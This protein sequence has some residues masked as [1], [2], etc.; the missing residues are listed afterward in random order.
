MA[1]GRQREDSPPQW[2]PSGAQDPSP[3]PAHGA[4]GY[5]PSYRACQPGT[6]HG[7][8]P[9]SYTAR[10]NGFNGDHAVTAEQ[11]SARIVQE[12]TAEAVAVLKGEQE[13]RLPSV[14]DTANLP[15]SPPPSP[16]AEHCFG[17]LDQDVGDEEEEACPLHHFQNSRERCKFLAPSIS[18]SMPEDDPY[19]SDE[20]YYDHPLF[21][22]EWDRSVSSR[23]SVPAAAFRQIQE[24]VEALTDTFEEEEE[25]VL[26][27]EEEEMEGA[28]AEIVAALEELW[29][30]DEPELDS[31]PA[32][33]LEQAEAIGEAHTVP[34]VQAEAASAAPE[35]P[36]RRVEEKEE[37]VAEAE[38]EEESPEEALKMDMDKPDSERSGSLSPDFTEQES[39]AF[40]SGDHAAA[41]L[42]PKTDMDPPSP[43]LSSLPSNSQSQAKELSKMSILD[44]R[45]TVS[46]KQPS[47]EVLESSNLT[48]DSGSGF[49]RAEDRGQGQGVPSDSNKDKSGMSAYFETSAL[50]PDEGSKGV[51][52]EGYYELSTAGEEK[53][54]LGSSSPTVPSPLEINYSMLAQTQSVEEKSDTKKSLMGDQKETLPALDR[55]NECRLSPGK[56]ALDQRSY[57]LNITIGSIDPSGHGL[58]RNFS[59]LATDIMSFTSGSLEES[60]NYLPVTTP[61]VE[62]EPTPFPPLI[63]ETAASV[64]SD[65]SSPPHDTATETP[66][67]KTSPQGSESPESPFPPKY[68]YKNGTVMAPDLPEMLDLAGSR[69][70]LASENTDPEIM[71]RKSVPADAQGLGSDSLAN[72]VLGDQSQ[73][74]SLAKS[75]S[76]LEELGYCVFSEYSGPMPSPADLHSPIDSPPQRFT[77]MALEEK[78]AEEKL[79]IDARDKLAED[80]KT[81]QLAESAGSNEKEETKQMGQKDSASEEKDNKK[82]SHEN[83]SMENQKDKPASAL[84]SAESFV[85]PTVTV[86]L[87]EEEKLGDNGP[88]T[89][90]EIAAYERQ[91]RRLEMEDRPLSMEEEREL[92]ELREKVKDK[93]L[94]H[95]EAYEEVDA[96]DVYQLTGVAKDRI[97]RPVRPS[98]ASSVESTTEEDNVSV[99]ETEKPKQTG[100]QTTPTK[101]DVMAMSPS[102]S[103]DCVSTT[104][105][106]KVPVTETEKPKQNGS[107]T[108]PK[109]VDIMVTSPSL[110]VGGVSTTEEDK[111]SVTETEKPKQ[112]GG[113]TTPT[114]L[115]VMEMSPSV[116]GDGVSTTEEDKVPV[117]ETE[118]PKQNGGQTTPKKVDIMVMS[119]SVS[120]GGVSTTEEDKVSVT[121]TE[122]PKQ[123]GGQ[124]T[125]TKFDVMAMSPS[126]SGGVSTTEEDKVPVTVTETEKPKQT[127]GQTP[128]RVDIMVTSPSVSGD[129]VGTTEEEK[130]PVTETEKPKQTGG[131]TPTRV[132]IMVT[133][134]SVSGD[135]VSTTE[136]EKVPFTESE[137]PKQN[138]GQTTPTKVDIMTTS[139]SV[140]GGGGSTTEEEKVPVTETE[141]PKQNGGQTTPTKVDIMTTSPS[142]SG[143]GG[144][145]TEEE[146]EKVSEEKLKKEQVVEVK[147]KTM[148][149]K[150]KVEGEEEDTEQAVEPEEIMIKIK[151]SMPVEKEEKVEKDRMTNKEEEEEEDSEVLAGAAVID[152]QEP[153]AAIESVVTVE[154]DFITVVQ[155]IDEGEEPGHSVRFSAPPEPETPEEEEEESQEV[156]IMEA[157][158][159]EEVGD[160]SEEALEKEVQASPEKEV[161]LETEG[162]TESYDRDETTMDDSIL[163]SSWVDTQDLSTVDVDDDM[164][165]ATEQIDP[166][167]ADRVPAPPVK[168][169][170]TLQQQKQEKQPVKPK[171][172]GGRVKG[173]EGCVSTPERKPVRKETVYIPREDIKK[174]KAVIKKTE[175]TKKAETR[176]SP[177]RKSVLKPTAVR[178]PRPAQPQPHPCARRKPTV[179]VPE[180]RRPLSVAR[181]SRDRASDGGSQSPK[182]SSLPRPASVP[183]PASILSRR[184]HHQPHDQEESS[185]SITSSGST[186][187]RRPTSFSTE[188]R[189]EH[190]TGR[191]PSWT[192]TQSMR[193]RSLCTTTRTPGSTA[194]SP[195][196]PPS[197]SYSC[198]TPGTPLTPGTPRSRSLLQEKK[199]ALLRTPPKSPATTP[200]QLRILNQPLPDLKNI[201]SK[202]GSTD[203]IKYQPKGGQIQILNK[204]LDFSHVQSKCGSKDNMKHSPR[205][206][207]VLIPSVKLDFSHVQSR[208]GSLDKRQYA[209]G[210]GNVQIQTKKIDLSHVTSKCG[211]L[212]N[213]RHRPGG[214]N[215]RIE[216]VK[217]D[218]KD[219][220]QPKVGSLDNAHHTPGGGHIMIES[221]KLLFR[222]T[223]KARV[224]HGAEIIMTQS[225]EMGMSGTVSPH[226]D[227]HLS[228]SGSINLLESP[229]LATLAEDVTAALAKQGL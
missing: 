79:K 50:K 60:A 26:M 63:L 146:N 96:E 49:T 190:R 183:R 123:T 178:H 86:T 159:L 3:P 186:A 181:Q 95:Q 223:A 118:K 20:E 148:E 176:S 121:E 168:K 218:F 152:V 188:V 51:Q 105:E 156:E 166:L 7:A 19:H 103:G 30:G 172:K 227:S 139:P 52:A 109:K 102:V 47:V 54:V 5:P 21:S 12:V 44:E 113:Q 2:D 17:P 32:E 224:D 155:T 127:G 80:E 59:P 162:Q 92:Q 117:T 36:D 161:Q 27:L 219:K 99:T 101:L 208:C 62:K 87:E 213:I 170:K 28:A 67:E 221:H 205:G 180:G 125:P 119:P 130:V 209:A 167:R 226:R 73:N 133:S 106:G 61:S 184:T 197:Y 215:V 200:K 198:R 141:K 115:D 46:E 111:V 37:E 15:P 33:P 39:P 31:P 42:I 40:L 112:T 193:S 154:D 1:D 107:Q 74:Q 72:L 206:G 191:A 177:S 164:S 128:T 94:V 88:E 108:M 179:G 187:P 10:E 110:S 93:F 147:E 75:E 25:E 71:R 97:G 70:R 77:P 140:S 225:P 22:P 120:V 212:D 114:K 56:L 216:S 18:V 135:G 214:G 122:K 217:L 66:G 222:D 211:S 41:P 149:E 58:P 210:G 199:V 57:S 150:K 182:R 132:D 89:D 203:N 16:A 90:A 220:A 129:G 143:G 4:N 84:K 134:P 204:K 100:G 104:E 116:A 174:K 157:A 138:G 13:T 160:V 189:A 48:T 194:I 137:K 165:M 145:T 34:P 8:A 64:T 151:A 175:L 55:S 163:D 131:Q 158:S 85:T 6:A 24:T 98:P 136:D 196:T 81:S 65:S 229:Q 82:I 68:Y 126:V 29:S 43:S 11:V 202:I 53:K 38:G 171:A 69:S 169:Y 207:H 173:R 195:G 45:K 23:P 192:G 14:E 124:T 142:V 228:S 185:T 78:M 201:K 144:S 76:Q 91:I 83:V 9:P 35:G 153:R